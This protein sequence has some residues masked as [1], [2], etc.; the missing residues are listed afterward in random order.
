M[1]FLRRVFGYIDGD[2]DPKDYTKSKLSTEWQTEDY[3]CYHCKKSTGHSE[4]MSDICNSCGS[5][6]T[7]VRFGRVYRKIYLNGKWR[8][9]VRYKDD[10]EEII[11]NWY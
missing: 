3:Y 4:Y 8:F 2:K 1:K 6:S 9:Q 7:Q 5:F 11:D 10:R